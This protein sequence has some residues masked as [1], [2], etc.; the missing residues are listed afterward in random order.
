MTM[1]QNSDKDRP[2]RRGRA[3][4]GKAAAEGMNEF[5]R[6]AIMAACAGLLS[7]CGSAGGAS[8]PGLALAP[9]EKQAPA[10]SAIMAELRGG[11]IGGPIGRDLPQALRREALQAEYRAL[12]YLPGGEPA[13]WG[14]PARGV[15]GEA[16]AAQPYSVGSQNCRQYS[17]TVYFGG[18]SRTARGTAC[19]NPDG[20]W[21][22]LI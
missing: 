14:D 1:G 16:V 8:P 2:Y 7:A 5:W 20:S 9:T 15:H 12:E 17:Q 19:R 6:G 3:I 13:G 10:S 22:P 4:F 18:A 21:T 11:L